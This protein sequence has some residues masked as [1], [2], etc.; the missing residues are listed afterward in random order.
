MSFL[1]RETTILP[2]WKHELMNLGVKMYVD[3]YGGSTKKILKEREEYLKKL[4]KAEGRS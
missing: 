3:W 1:G 4:R 2:H